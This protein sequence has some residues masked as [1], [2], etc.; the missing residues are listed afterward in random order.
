MFVRAQHHRRPKP[1]PKQGQQDEQP[2][3]VPSSKEASKHETRGS[4]EDRHSVQPNHPPANDDAAS[5]NK[6]PRKRRTEREERKGQTKHALKAT[7]QLEL[8]LTRLH[9]T[10][11]VPT[12]EESPKLH[13]LLFSDPK[14][15]LQT[16]FDKL[17]N[18][19]QRKETRVMRHPQHPNLPF[20]RSTVTF[21]FSDR[22]S[23][24][25]SGDGWSVKEAQKAAAFHAVAKLHEAGLLLI[26]WASRSLSARLIKEGKGGIIDVFNYAARH[27]CIPHHSVQQITR[28]VVLNIEMPEHGIK[29]TATGT[30]LLQAEMLASREFKKQAEAYHLRT[31]TDP[32]VVNDSMILNADNA[33]DFVTFCRNTGKAWVSAVAVQESVLGP[34]YWTAQAKRKDEALGP[35]VIISEGG[36]RTAEKI[37]SLVGALMLV[38]EKPQLLEDF[39]HASLKGP[40]LK[41]QRPIDVVVERETLQEI[42][43]LTKSTTQSFGKRQDETPKGDELESLRRGRQMGKLTRRE[44]DEKSKELRLR[45]ASY[46]SRPDLEQLRHTRSCL[47]MSQYAQQV[48]EIVQNNIYCIIV[49]ATGSGKTTQV[50]QI[51]LDQAIESGT[52]ASCNVVCTQPR[53]IAATSVARRVAD[54]RAEKLQ[55][56]VGY[57]VRFDAKLPNPSGSILFCTTG[58]LLQQLQNAHDEVYDR[59]SHLVIDEVHERDMIIDFLLVILKK[60]MALRVAQG[61]KVP[62][63]ILMSATIDA[64][65]FSEYFKNSLPSEVPTDCPSLNVPGRAFPVKE[66]Y[67]ADVLQELEHD[68]GPGA[69]TLLKSDKGTRDYLEA[70]RDD[71]G[72]GPAKVRDSPNPVIDWKATVGP[73]DEAVDNKDKE[74]ALVPVGLAA[75]AVAHIAKTTAGGAI[76][77]FLPGLDDILSLET[78]LRERQPLDVDFNDEKKFR[79]FMLHSTIRDQK[80][81]FD[82]LPHGCRKIILST[83][84]A[85]TS[86]TIPEVQFVVDT[87]KSREKRYDQTR[88]I[89]QLQCGWISKSNVKQRAGRAGRVQNGHYYALYTKSRLESLRAV[90]LPEL[91]RSELQE[92]CLD[93]KA[94]SFKM[95]VRDFLAEALE[96]PPPAAVDIALES[97]I[98]LGALTEKEELTPLGRVLAT[99]PVHPT[100]GKMIIL[101]IIFRCLEPMIILGAAAAERPLFVQPP[102]LRR[103]VDAIK[104][105]FAGS[106]ESDHIMILEAF[107][108]TRRAESYGRDV[109]R[110]WCDEHFVHHGAFKSIQS[111][112]NQIQE[113]LFD[114]GLIEFKSQYGGKMLNENSGSEEVIKALLLAGLSPNLAIRKPGSSRLN[115][116]TRDEAVTGIHP[117]S[118]NSSALKRDD[119]QLLTFA[120]LGLAAN[121]GRVAMRDTTIVTPLMA[122]FF[123]GPLS[124]SG[125]FLE[126]QEWLRFYITRARGADT[127]R[128]TAAA[129]GIWTLRERLDNMLAIAFSD[130]AKKE[131][132]ANDAQRW[133]LASGIAKILELN[134][135]EKVAHDAEPLNDR[136]LGARP[137]GAVSLGARLLSAGSHDGGLHEDRPYRTGTL[138]DRLLAT[139]C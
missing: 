50:P 9:E 115:F 101:G 30:E 121:G 122:I 76:L 139:G 55:D 88:R 72:K 110:R 54:E 132:L 71:W 3:A 111:T 131:P 47:P 97:L 16:S 57:H 29:V 70:E 117:S 99:L 93:V 59:V 108:K 40:I 27:G 6:E 138:G 44:L 10:L 12:K 58:I 92:V 96:P 51:L 39:K 118:V 107:R 43:E 23:I 89:T 46:Q 109:V 24:V 45:L 4:R 95:A 38:K 77:V 135:P 120:S 19:K 129:H 126:L 20:H 66:R 49:G 33:A 63:V 21:Q 103:R 98:N 128:S 137:L 82:S 25:A 83:N 62:R 69:L 41:K 123:S 105:R 112:A 7:V 8:S 17:K 94:Q 86:V 124:T 52:G 53:R 22:D 2:A 37:A 114:A 73:G 81:V 84:I 90:G 68:H 133:L 26:T 91:L 74:E 31:G 104:K 56:T 1:R 100:L 130:L 64:E 5:T 116:C 113:V 60:T 127:V 75:T 13:E 79:I 78:M 34:H 125:K 11:K 15:T 119:Q 102:G 87:G 35:P 28:F 18:C 36:K 136:L 48:Q 32:S 61:R 67:L 14:Q 85:E 106:S 42:I 134:A 65:R 80:T